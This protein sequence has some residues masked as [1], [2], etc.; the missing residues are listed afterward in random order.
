MFD[1]LE[2]GL[3]Y[4]NMFRDYDPETGRYLQSDPIGL[5]GGMNTYAYVG[6]NPISYVDPLGLFYDLCD[7]IKAMPDSI[8][9]TLSAGLGLGLGGSGSL[10]ITNDGISGSVFAGFA[11]GAK[12]SW[13]SAV[14]SDYTSISKNWGGQNGGFKVGTKIEGSAGYGVLATTSGEFGTNGMTLGAG[15]EIGA[16]LFGGVGFSVSGSILN[17]KKDGGC[18]K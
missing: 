12:G 14:A 2:K 16:G 6:G 7:L 18:K 9:G 4:Y 11:G 13:K 8:K 15:V 3:A 17:C 5:A 10:A 1:I